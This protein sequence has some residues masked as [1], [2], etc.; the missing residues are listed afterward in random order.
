L[1]SPELF[2]LDAEILQEQRKHIRARFFGSCRK[3]LDDPGFQPP[4]KERTH[5]VIS[6]ALLVTQYL[7]LL[8]SNK[9]T[10]SAGAYRSCSLNAIP[11]SMAAS[12][13]LVSKDLLKGK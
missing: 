8:A 4:E 11:A 12:N 1:S 9:Q 7:F 5:Q 3:C 13:S 10:N 6:S 2:E